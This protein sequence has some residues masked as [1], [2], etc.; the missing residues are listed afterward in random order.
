MVSSS[1]FID[2]LPA[3]EGQH[4][5][6][7]RLLLLVRHVQGNPHERRGEGRT[8]LVVQTG[9]LG[10]SAVLWLAMCRVVASQCGVVPL[11]LARRCC[12]LGNRAR[13]DAAVSSC[14]LRAQLRVAPYAM[15]P[16]LPLVRSRL[17]GPGASWD[18]RRKYCDPARSSSCV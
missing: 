11:R 3:C 13:M 7:Q 18:M 15:S 4:C 2:I 5:L 17:G 10:P 16:R 8:V 1:L 12:R 6:D 9:H 14:V